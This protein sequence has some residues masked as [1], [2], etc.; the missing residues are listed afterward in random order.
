MEKLTGKFKK[1]VSVASIASLLQTPIV[2][3]EGNTASQNNP[4][5]RATQVMDT[6]TSGIQMY[7]QFLQVNNQQ[8]LQQIQNQ[9]LQKQLA[10]L[11]PT[12]VPS[13][14][15]PEC[16]ITPSMSNSV[17]DFCY[18]E[19]SVNAVNSNNQ[20]KQ[21]ADSWINTLN[22]ILNKASNGQTEIGILCLENRQK[23][24]DDNFQELI[25]NLT[26]LEQQLNAEKENFRKLNASILDQMKTLK[27][28]LSGGAEGT[29]LDTKTKDY[30]SLFSKDCQTIIAN[31]TAKLAQSGGLMG[32]SA[33]LASGKKLANDHNQNKLAIEKE[34][35]R[36]VQKAVDHVKKYGIGGLSTFNASE[37]QYK[38]LT[39]QMTSEVQKFTVNYQRIQQE[40]KKLDYDV[41]VLDK[42]FTVDL[43]EFTT[44]A[45]DY[46]KKRYINQC[47]TGADKTG[48]ALST[49]Q[50]LN[51]LKQRSTNNKGTAAAQYKVAL[52]NIIN[53]DAFIQDKVNQIKALENNYK[54]ISITYRSSNGQSV[55]SSPYDLYI[56][57]I[58]LCEQQYASSNAASS[59]E[60]K[61]VDRGV[62]LLNELQNFNN[63]FAS[64]FTTNA[65]DALLNCNGNSA[66]NGLAKNS[67][68]SDAVFDF[69]SDNYCLSIANT[70]ANTMVGCDAEITNQITIRK[71]KQKALAA[72]YNTNMQ[73]MITKA[74]TLVKA[75]NTAVI[76]MMK[77]IQAKLPGT[78][79][80]IPQDILIETPALLSKNFD[81]ALLGDG[82]L[83][84]MDE[85]NKK[86]AILKDSISNQRGSTKDAIAEYIQKQDEAARAELKK[87]G[88][89]YTDC[90]Q[91]EQDSSGMIAQ[92]NQDG[93]KK[94]AEE[95][96]KV[97]SF[98]RKY[99]A[100]RNNPMA[101]CGGSL[102]KLTDTAAEIAAFGRLSKNADH[103]L[104][105]YAAL[106][107]QV[108][109]EDE[110]KYEN[111]KKALKRCNDNKN[112]A[113]CD[114][115]H[116]DL[117]RAK[118]KLGKNKD[119]EPEDHKTYADFC[120]NKDTSDA[121]LIKTLANLEK[122]SS[123]QKK[124][125]NMKNLEKFKEEAEELNLKN[126]EDFFDVIE[127]EIGSDAFNGSGFCSKL[128]SKLNPKRE[129]SAINSSLDILQ[130]KVT[131]L[132]TEKEAADR[133][134]T[135]AKTDVE[136][137]DAKTA[138]DEVL[139]NLKEAEDELRK[140]QNNP[141]EETDKVI[142]K[143]IND[144]V[145]K[146]TGYTA[147]QERL[148]TAFNNIGEQTTND[149]DTQL[150]STASTNKGND[151]LRAF[152]ASIL[153]SSKAK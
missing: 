140:T 144:G 63:N 14:M 88:D 153:G 152:D 120:K 54:D 105:Q 78:N 8:R 53:S 137:K 32:I 50:V 138:F 100:L 61:K 2:F 57:Q 48:V 73:N 36:D 75:Q 21:L 111:A 58:N 107:A 4:T 47:V 35:R 55:T 70:C 104:N 11:S 151:F 103:S 67:C 60:K 83:G 40:L 3:A 19:A 123:N 136:K 118:S 129:I 119:D 31:Q 71:N 66:K 41:P 127:D 126:Y 125:A 110:T 87:W 90:S 65:L 1:I 108:N 7:S 133:K 68:V 117:D 28:E 132:K 46:F 86:L 121:Q 147:P 29:N 15:F 30:T 59:S 99:G 145:K 12:V 115:E 74:N 33:G 146:L 122:D 128:Y 98:C 114:D 56:K 23:S 142:A 96:A 92:M 64:T 18:A 42:N 20:M 131:K 72:T 143:A 38:A 141:K 25:N 84:V 80:D 93:M 101:G 124:L 113:N 6:V 13:K 150:S 85:I 97:G 89:V 91:K 51:A 39:T 102:E 94:Q 79:I 5:K 134:L 135:E 10:S 106:C 81:V 44:Q 130:T 69:T 17:K 112:K 149:C 43:N 148:K 95:D 82:N 116:D 76:A 24:L 37:T 62:S 77:K 22:K 27:S 34:I 26:R 52:E 49:D 9:Q 109:N 139:A 16:A 45:K